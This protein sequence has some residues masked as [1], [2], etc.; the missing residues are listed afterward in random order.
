M[1][2]YKP[3]KYFVENGLSELGERQLRRRALQAYRNGEEY[4]E[5]GKTENGKNLYLIDETRINEFA[6]RIRKP[7]S[8]KNIENYFNIEVSVNFNDNSDHAYYSEIVSLFR[9]YTGYDLVYKIESGGKYD[10]HLHM[11]IHGSYRVVRKYINF[12][13][14]NIL[15][16]KCNKF[17]DSSTGEH[18][19]SLRIRKIIDEEAF[20]DYISK[21]YDRLGG[22]LPIY[23]FN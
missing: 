17:Y 2:N 15:Q 19:S 10:N 6:I 9:H 5:L 22:D 7:K 21:G 8:K 1:N 4:V 13:L 18:K 20:V 11:G 16:R 14:N 12:I 3:I 23:L